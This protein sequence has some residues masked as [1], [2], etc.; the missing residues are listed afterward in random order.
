MR[1]L[2]ELPIAIDAK[3][4]AHFCQLHGVRRL[5]LFGSVL[6]DDFASDSDIDMLVEYLPGRH[7]GLMLFRQ[8]DE[9]AVQFGRAVDLHTPGSLSRHFRDE[10]LAEA[11]SVYEQA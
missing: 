4:I 3:G 1:T 7:P 8:Q 6:R 5:A 2:A 9:L 11:L 10:V